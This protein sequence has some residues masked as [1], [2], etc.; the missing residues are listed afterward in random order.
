MAPRHKGWG[1]MFTREAAMY[2]DSNRNKKEF[3]GV[4]SFAVNVHFSYRKL[5]FCG[6]SVRHPP[7]LTQPS[8]YTDF[9]VEQRGGREGECEE[10]EVE[11]KKEGK[12]DI[13]RGQISI[14]NACNFQSHFLLCCSWKERS[15]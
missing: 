14:D 7:S 1:Q 12:K 8:H 3:T 6:Q 5:V 15:K 4:V 2:D 9:Q 10:D 13:D 11:R